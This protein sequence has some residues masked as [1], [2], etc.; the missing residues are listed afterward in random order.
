MHTSIKDDLLL[1]ALAV[2]IMC[3]PDAAENYAA[4]AT[5]ETVRIQIESGNTLFCDINSRLRVAVDQYF[6]RA[7]NIVD[8][9]YRL[10]PFYLLH[11]KGGHVNYHNHTGS[12]LTGILYVNVPSGGL[13]LYDPR[14]NANRGMMSAMLNSGAFSPI[15]LR[16]ERGDLI[17]FPSYVFHQG[18]PNYS[19]EPRIV[20]PFDVV[21]DENDE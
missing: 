15:E 2:A 4:K 19:N 10:E 3:D 1:D 6:E 17:I 18:T 12:S 11:Q 16:P 21:P 20:L 13:T 8:A 7:Y 14:T 9:E 5:K